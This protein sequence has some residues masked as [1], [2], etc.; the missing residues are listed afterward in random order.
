MSKI[1]IFL[2]VFAIVVIGAMATIYYYQ[3]V[4]VTPEIT[5]QSNEQEPTQNDNTNAPVI[6]ESPSIEGPGT[7]DLNGMKYRI[8]YKT[9]AEGQPTAF[10]VLTGKINKEKTDLVAKQI[11]ADITGTDPALKALIL[12]FYS[13]GSLV[14]EHKIDVATISWTPE[15]TSIKMMGE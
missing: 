14:D 1:K 4:P 9:D 5:Q 15:K 13:E 7:Q 8:I 10:E 3:N 2:A 6:E 12:N 11:I